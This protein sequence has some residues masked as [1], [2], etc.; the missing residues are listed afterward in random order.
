[1]QVGEWAVSSNWKIT[2]KL[3]AEEIPFAQD[4]EYLLKEMRATLDDESLHAWYE[5][6]TIRFKTIKRTVMRA[7]SLTWKNIIPVLASLAR[8]RRG[9]SRFLR[10]AKPC[11]RRTPPRQTIVLD[12]CSS[13]S[14]RRSL[15]DAVIRRAYHA[16]ASRSCSGSGD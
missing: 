14:A 9:R 3:R 6:C 2:A 11:R 1:M 12:I 10:R 8:S 13:P 5:A 15:H 4:L 16:R 7:C